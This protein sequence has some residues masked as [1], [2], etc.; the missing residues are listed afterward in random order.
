[1]FSQVYGGNER[2]QKAISLFLWERKNRERERGS[3][4]PFSSQHMHCLAF[5][6]NFLF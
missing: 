5:E 3:F 1:M 2:Q 4:S 6:T